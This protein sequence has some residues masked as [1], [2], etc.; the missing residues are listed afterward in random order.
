MK[1]GLVDVDGQGR[2]FPNLCLMKLSSWH[3]AQGDQVE[4]AGSLFSYDKIYL[5]KV[6]DHTYTRDD[7]QA[8]NAGE[9]IRGG[10]GYDL[11]SKLPNDVE[12]SFPDYSLYG[13]TDTAY[14][15]LTR[16]C[17]RHCPFCIV[18]DK[19]GLTS[20]KV[21]D[22]SE[23][24]SGQKNIMLLDPNIMACSDWENLFKQLIDSKAVVN[25]T[26][27]VDI[28]LMTVAKAEMLSKVRMKFLHFAWD[29]PEDEVTPK[30]LEKYRS[31]F[32]QRDD[33]MDVY[34][35]VNFNS[36]LTEDLDRI[37]RLKEI[38]Y[39]PYV[40]VY[41]KPHASSIIRKLQRWCNDKWVFRSVDIFSEY[42][43]LTAAEVEHII[44]GQYADLKQK[45]L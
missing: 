15:Y 34:V 8:Y 3:K 11:S 22:L 12:H 20:V 36:T 39:D 18:G 13:I 32:K 35:L 37:Y 30:Q 25:L 5:A 38:G 43:K 31:Y 21:A 6:F 9:I 23:F 16:G 1:I 2:R 42:D 44:W 33:R 40:M 7:L 19:E 17:P 24:W 45:K 14:G 27:G 28:R 10:T 26:Q 29:N 4:W 41:D